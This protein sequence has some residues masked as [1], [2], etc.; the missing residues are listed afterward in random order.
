MFIKDLGKNMWLKRDRVHIN[1]ITGENAQLCLMYLEYGEKTD[2]NHPH[3]QVGYIT[4]GS[5]ALT[6]DGVTEV[7]YP[8]DGYHIPSHVQHGFE[9]LEKEGLRF[10]EIFS[11]V[12][13]E[14]INPDE[15]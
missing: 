4:E 1:S 11:P 12:K 13:Q 15:R 5:V 2:H 7:L 6:I 10:L 14:N 8:G 3:E 9:V